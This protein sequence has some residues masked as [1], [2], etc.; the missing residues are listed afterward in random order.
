[1]SACFCIVRVVPDL[2]NEDKRIEQYAYRWAAMLKV[3][4]SQVEVRCSK[5]AQVTSPVFRIIM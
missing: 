4:S 5:T 2:M 1:M 3:P